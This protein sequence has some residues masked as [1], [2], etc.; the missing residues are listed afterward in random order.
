VSR[1]LLSV[2]VVITESR[3]LSSVALDKDFFVE[4]PIKST[5][6]SAEH[7]AKSRISVV[8]VHELTYGGG[9]MNSVRLIN[10]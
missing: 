7:L 6:Q 5:R 4:C 8:N 1:V 3:T 10:K 9:L 2:N